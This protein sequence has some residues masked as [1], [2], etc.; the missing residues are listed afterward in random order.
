M[1]CTKYQGK[2]IIMYSLFQPIFS[3]KFLC[4]RY[5]YCRNRQ[6]NRN[7]RLLSLFVLVTLQDRYYKIQEIMK[8]KRLQKLA[9][10]YSPDL[11]TSLVMP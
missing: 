6:A 10:D 1:K 8:R 4:Q 9:Y 7:M 3:S 2:E 5:K 11:P